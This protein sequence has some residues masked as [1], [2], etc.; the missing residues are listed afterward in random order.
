[1]GAFGGGDLSS[2]PTAGNPMGMTQIPAT[3][4]T[5]LSKDATITDKGA[6]KLEISGKAKTLAQDLF[7][8]ADPLLA[9][10]PGSSKTDVDKMKE[11]LAQIPDS[12]TLTF[13]VT[14]KD[15]AV[16]ELSIDL[17][18]F[19]PA[20]DTGGGHLPLDMKI[21]QSAPA[22]SAPS[23]VTMLDIN[24]LMSSMGPGL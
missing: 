22:V 11:S 8:A 10:V 15:G 18:Q 14:L 3:V 13:D 6:G 5:A 23:G 19:L 4:I 1:M 24:K 12:Q 16:S 9:N 2:A 21:S 7:Q 17:A 20:T